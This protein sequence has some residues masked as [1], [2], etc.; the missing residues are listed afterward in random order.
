VSGND[1][2]HGRST[3]DSLGVNIIGLEC[4]VADVATLLFAES[5]DKQHE[6]I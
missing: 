5:Y 2:A 1:G 3:R 4:Q 6:F